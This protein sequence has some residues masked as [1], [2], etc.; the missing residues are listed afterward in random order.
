VDSR[1]EEL[2]NA[3]PFCWTW[4]CGLKLERQHCMCHATSFYSLQT[5]TLALGVVRW[6]GKKILSDFWRPCIGICFLVAPAAATS[7]I[8]CYASYRHVRHVLA[9]QL[10]PLFMDGYANGDSSGAVC[11]CVDIAVWFMCAIALVVFDR[12]LL[13]LAVLILARSPCP[14]ADAA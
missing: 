11:L 6:H 9:W 7:S 4:C 5:S 8:E 10:P 1:N 13:L 2:N 3:M 12:L 14:H